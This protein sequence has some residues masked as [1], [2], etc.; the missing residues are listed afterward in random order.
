[1]ALLNIISKRHDK[2]NIVITNL[3]DHGWGEMDENSVST[4]GFSERFELEI[5]R[6]L[7]NLQKK[8]NHI[9]KK[10]YKSFQKRKLNGVKSLQKLRMKEKRRAR[11][12]GIL[13][14]KRNAKLNEPF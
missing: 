13:K 9:L 10:K 14:K 3:K 1:M 2:I 6:N 7:Y 8:K 11:S 5:S 4:V 12:R